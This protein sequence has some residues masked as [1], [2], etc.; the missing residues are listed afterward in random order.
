MLQMKS[1]AVVMTDI[2]SDNPVM[3]TIIVTMWNGCCYN[4]IIQ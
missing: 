1:I 4:S 2:Q 3:Y